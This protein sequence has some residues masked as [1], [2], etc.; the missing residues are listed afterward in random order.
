MKLGKKLT[1][2]CLSAAMLCGVMLS[3]GAVGAEQ[4]ATEKKLSVAVIADPQYC[5]DSSG[6]VPYRDFLYDE[7]AAIFDKAIEMVKAQ[8]PDLLF[9][10]GDLTSYGIKSEFEAVEKKLSEV[11][12]AGIQVNVT[13]GPMDCQ[14]E[15]GVT[16]FLKIFKNYG[17]SDAYLVHEAK[18]QLSTGGPYVSRP[19]D[20]LSFVI[21][22]PYFSSNAPGDMRWCE[23]QIKE[24]KKRG[25][26]VIGVISYPELDHA[27]DSGV[28]EES[29]QYYADAGLDYLL[30]SD[31]QHMNDIMEF[32]SENDNSFYAIQTNSLSGYGS[33]VRFI[34]ITTGVNSDG[35]YF[36]QLDIKTER[37]ESVSI[38]GDLIEN[39]REYTFDKLFPADVKDGVEVILR[40][41]GNMM[42]ESMKELLEE[43][44]G[45]KLGYDGSIENKAEAIK[46]IGEMVTE[47]FRS[48]PASKDYAVKI[49][50]NYSIYG[51]GKGAVIVFDKKGREVTI[52][53][54]SAAAWFVSILE[55]MLEAASFFKY[56]QALEDGMTAALSVSL[57]GQEEYT[58]YDIL[59]ILRANRAYGEED[60]TNPEWL[61]NYICDDDAMDELV[62]LMNEQ[63]AAAQGDIVSE[64]LKEV[65]THGDSLIVSK[66]GDADSVALKA[67]IIGKFG[68]NLYE[69][70]ERL[71]KMEG[72]MP[73]TEEDPTLDM[74]MFG[75][76]E[77]FPTE[78]YL[79]CF[80]PNYLEDNDTVIKTVRGTAPVTPNP[81]PDPGTTDP[82]KLPTGDS[83][84]A[85]V[86]VLLGLSC[87][88]LLG[89]GLRKR[90]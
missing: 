48:I 85:G 7:S 89:L 53:G 87:A 83:G 14:G 8:K 88:A 81:K 36:D 24:A 45:I 26:T 54:E 27:Y 72:D 59:C 60:A 13:P 6:R 31:T 2:L 39:L 76:F 12:A 56:D 28:T 35:K 62:M 71:S 15:G 69:M 57:P 75:G 42:D 52:T 34:D 29:V 4:K 49:S 58:A 73:G 17:Y 46:N 21:G 11:K 5:L 44:L 25:D 66:D 3:A 78:L 68:Q 20:G 86:C 61:R 41:Y 80:D 30:S 74:S 79:L 51:D 70:N 10:I 16:E 47:M 1:A 64:L 50:Y 40:D 65:G 9:V 19:M 63:S 67:E 43:T 37:V 33:P 32:T 22:I 82:G 23:E 84:V 38:N 55:D 18:N 90:K 77:S